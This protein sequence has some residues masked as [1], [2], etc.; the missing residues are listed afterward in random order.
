MLFW[1]L[2]TVCALL[3]TGPSQ[4]KAPAKDKPSATQPATRPADGNSTLRKPAQAE[5]LKSLLGRDERPTPIHPQDP[6]PRDGARPTPTGAAVD[7]RTLMLEGAFL[8]ERPGRLVHEDGRAKLVISPEA[9]GKGPRTL[10]ILP[11]QL[12]EAMEHE[13]EA[14]FTEFIVSAEVTR[15]KDAN[16]MILR[17]MLRRVG[18]GNLSP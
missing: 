6:A 1:I 9:E 13:A 10:E 16:Y 2:A 17:K 7:G 11:N 8:V 4:D 5:I 12:L 14:G 15:Y 3:Q 18:H